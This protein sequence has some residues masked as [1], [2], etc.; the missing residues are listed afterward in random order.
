MVFANSLAFLTF[1]DTNS[2]CYDHF[3]QVSEPVGYLVLVPTVMYLPG[4]VLSYF[5]AGY[6]LENGAKLSLVVGG[7][8][9]VLGAGFKLLSLVVPRKSFDGVLGGQILCGFA[10]PLIMNVIVKVSSNW[11]PPVERDWGLRSIY[12]AHPPGLVI[13]AL[14]AS[15]LPPLLGCSKTMWLVLYST[16]GS[17]MLLTLLLLLIF[18]QDM[19]KD[20][21]GKLIAPS[22]SSYLMIK[23]KMEFTVGIKMGPLITKELSTLLRNLDFFILLMSFSILYG[24]LTALIVTTVSSVLDFTSG[25]GADIPL[26]YLVLL[27]AGG[28]CG[29][30]L[31]GFCFQLRPPPHVVR[32]IGFVV[33]AGA[34]IFLGFTVSS[35]SL[36]LCGLAF[37]LMGLVAFPLLPICLEAAAETTYDLP[38]EIFT[39]MLLLFGNICF[40]VIFMTLILEGGGSFTL[41]MAFYRYD[42]IVLMVIGAILAL[43]SG[44]PYERT[45]AERSHSSKIR[46]DSFYRLLGRD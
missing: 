39:G 36:I 34:T 27:V 8:L 31:Y 37:F 17:L 5:L 16:Q 26:T 22:R 1:G 45:Y 7:F 25:Q 14:L 32:K 29:N 43:F 41:E 24:L 9:S 13:G 33:A 46:E 20:T 38:E 15:R 3:Y 19:Q 18:F 6:S 42:S 35:R 4:T 12:M 23:A 28:L 40:V 11:F 2:S 30:I 21:N 44:G 10:Q